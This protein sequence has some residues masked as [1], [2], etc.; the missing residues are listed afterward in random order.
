[1]TWIKTLWQSIPER[2]RAY[3]I[4]LAEWAVVALIGWLIHKYTGIQPE[5]VPF[6]VYVQVDA[7]C[8]IAEPAVSFGWIAP[9]DDERAIALATIKANQ[10]GLDP[11]FSKLARAAIEAVDADEA[12]FFWE[13]EMKVL[14]R[15]LPVWNQ[16]NIGSCV[17]HGVGRAIQDAIII[18]IAS[19][20]RE[21]WPGAELCR[22]ALYGGSRVE[23]G[24]G[25][26]RGDGSMNSW[27][28]A[29]AQK[30]GDRKSVV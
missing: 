19:G 15:L 25:Q 20:S 6:P 2:T 9:T 1:M 4:R 7:I 22:E 11:D 3:A 8:P 18:Q 27:A 10:G 13:A 17:S 21:A 26:I 12:V 24:G 14:K 23:I 16:S 29:F 30:Y 28:V 5:P